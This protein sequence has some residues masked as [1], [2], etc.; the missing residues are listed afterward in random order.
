MSS[1]T[2]MFILQFY[3]KRL[4]CEKLQLKSSRH[5]DTP[6]VYHVFGKEMDFTFPKNKQAKR[7]WW[8]TT[9][10]YQLFF[11]IISMWR[12][13][14]G[15]RTNR[16]T[17][18]FYRKKKQCCGWYLICFYTAYQTNWRLTRLWGFLS[19]SMPLRLLYTRE[20]LQSELKIPETLHRWYNA[21]YY[22]SDV[23]H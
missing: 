23:S 4:L 18:Y 3:F 6:K 19:R 16:F 15:K 11:F 8:R 10:F 13:L 20:S 7:R 21:L 14:N 2:W 5:S 22:S 12:N 1:I 9:S 17:V